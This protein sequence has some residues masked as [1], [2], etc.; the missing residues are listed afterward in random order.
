MVKIERKKFRII[1]DLSL[2]CTISLGKEYKQNYMQCQEVL[3]SNKYLSKHVSTGNANDTIP[4]DDGVLD[5][6]VK[7]YKLNNMNSRIE[8][9]DEKIKSLGI[10]LKDFLKSR[11]T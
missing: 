6:S 4:V 10:K 2:N 9:S 1:L 11:K 8:F 3:R 7:L 5:M